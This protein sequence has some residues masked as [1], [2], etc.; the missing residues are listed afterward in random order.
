M[1]LTTLPPLRRRLHLPVD[2]D[3]ENPPSVET[4]LCCLTESPPH[5]FTSAQNWFGLFNEASVAITDTHA[6]LEI[7]VHRNMNDRDAE[8][9]LKRFDAEV[10]GR[11]L[12]KRAQL[13]EIYLSSPWTA[14]MHSFDGGRIARDF[15]FRSHYATPQLAELQIEENELIRRYRRFMAEGR[16]IFDGQETQVSIVVGCLNDPRSS[17][18]KQAFLAYWG[19]L[20]ENE[21]KLQNLFDDLFTNRMEQTRRSGAANFIDVAFSELGRTDYGPKECL[22]FATSIEQTVVPLLRDL[23][24]RQC[25]TLQ[26]PTLRPWDAHIW[27][28]L[29]P[30]HNPAGGQLEALIAALGRILQQMH[31]AYAN[32]FEQMQANGL[33]DIHPFRGKSPGAFCVTLQEA[34]LPYVFGNFSGNF[35]DAFTLIHEFGHALHGHASSFIPNALLRTPGLEFCEVASIGLELMASTHF[36]ELWF[37]PRDQIRAQGLQL[38]NTLA[39]WPFMAMIDMWQHTVYS[40]SQSSPTQRNQIWRDLAQ[41]FRPH[42]DWTG[43]EHFE[44]LGWLSRPH[45]FTTPFYYIDYGIGQLGATQLYKS[46]KENPKETLQRYNEALARGG[47]IGLPK[48]FSQAGLDLDFSCGLLTRVVDTLVEN[49]E[50]HLAQLGSKA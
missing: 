47:Q 26:T 36:S 28:E 15:R 19:F 21:E 5:D 3:A 7:A 31:P 40:Q 33:I 10:L 38:F 41:R 8:S 12:R 32:L 13:M 37:D 43:F 46:Y 34:G 50:H 48:L 44:G 6:R 22:E 27:P 4:L 39:F 49:L 42:I 29:V 45:V 11:L 25:K 1:S 17:V 14:A 30:T 16:T 20:Y 23:S 18:R 9:R 24:K 35:K 2:F